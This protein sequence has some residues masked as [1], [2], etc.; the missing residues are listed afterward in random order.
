M[1]KI[2]ERINLSRTL[3]DEELDEFN[4]LTQVLYTKAFPFNERMVMTNEAMEEETMIDNPWN[5]N[6]ICIYIQDKNTQNFFI[7]T[8][9]YLINN[10]FKPKGIV[11]FGS[12]LGVDTT[13]GSYYAFRIINNEIIF[14][15]N[16]IHYLEQQMTSLSI[17]KDLG[18]ILSNLEYLI[19]QKLY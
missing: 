13:F 15:Q 5:V 10:F 2:F 16:S 17:S 9:L 12:I 11:V 1:D 18:Q 8:L 6:G 14:D 3:E 19:T 7:E 4:N